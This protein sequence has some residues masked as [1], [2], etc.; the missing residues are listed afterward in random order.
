MNLKSMNELIKRE[1]ERLE[2]LQIPLRGNCL[3]GEY[4]V[5]KGWETLDLDRQCR[6]C[7]RCGYIL[8]TA[9][10][11]KPRTETALTYRV[12]DDDGETD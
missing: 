12:E 2:R 9:A 3:G 5:A 4:H 1:N 8:T 7:I 11:P 6:R 10:I